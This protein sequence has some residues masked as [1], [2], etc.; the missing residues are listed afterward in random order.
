MLPGTRRPLHYGALDFAHPAHTVV[1]TLVGI[2]SLN[3]IVFVSVKDYGNIATKLPTLR[4]MNT[5]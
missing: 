3:N 4:L 2:V 5:K 1:T